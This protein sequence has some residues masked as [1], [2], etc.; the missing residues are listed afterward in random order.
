MAEQKD[1]QEGKRLG[2]A[3]LWLG[4]IA[5][6]AI[7]S[8]KS[9]MAYFFVNFMLIQLQISPFYC[10]AI[11]GA[12]FLS[13]MIATPI[14][15]FLSDRTRTK[16]GKRKPWILLAAIP[17]A[18]LFALLWQDFFDST[19]TKLGYLLVLVLVKGI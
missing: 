16:L 3:Q 15:G 2:V 7:A 11:T 1:E 19:N 6:A 8:T 12:Y 9:L 14:V 10:S 4:T 18:L 17:D 13:N 5:E